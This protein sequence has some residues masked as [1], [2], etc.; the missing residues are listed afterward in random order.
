MPWTAKD[1]DRH[2]K[3]LS[4]RQKRQW[5]AVA[6]SMLAACMKKGGSQS[7]CEGRAIRGANSTVGDPELSTKQ[8]F[9][10]NTALTVP[11][12]RLTLNECEFLTAPA[13]LIVCGV[14]N[15][16]LI[17]EEALLPEEW[18][19]VPVTIG[20]PIDANG[21]PVSARSSE[22]LET[23]A[24]GHLTNARLGMGYREG[25]PVRS[26]QADIWIDTARIETLGGAAL[27][28]MQML[29]RQ[30]PLEVSTGF[31]SAGLLQNGVFLGTPYAEVHNRIDPDHLALLPNAIGACSWENGG[32][33]APRLHEHA[34]GCQGETCTC[35][36]AAVPAQ[37]EEAPSLSR[38]Q[39]LWR[40]VREVLHGESDSPP[41]ATN[42]TDLDIR[43]ALMG[44]L[45]REQ[46]MTMMPWCIEDLDVANHTF[47]YHE[48]GRLMRRGWSI[49][50][51]I[52]TLDA[53]GEDVQRDTQYR[54][55]P[56]SEVDRQGMPGP[57]TYEQQETSMPAPDVIKRRVN[58][59]IANAR[60]RW[61]EED[62]HMLESCDEA[63]LIRLEHQ[64][65]EPLPTEP[66]PAPGEPT[67]MEEALETIPAQFRETMRAAT[68]AYTKR[69]N[70]MIET[71]VANKTNP[72]SREELE[73]MHADRLEKLLTMSGEPV[74]GQ[75]PAANG[76]NY[77]GRRMPHL[78]LVP[79]E[80][81]EAPPSPPDTMGL[82][83]EEQKRLGLR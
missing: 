61:T 83:I 45:T 20:H 50:N 78:R 43:E 18:D 67:T 49:D 24:V 54:P 9:T 2:K 36:A 70:A 76:A 59:L 34:C 75:T 25:H 16:A 74:P 13:V 66:P 7:E 80:E 44:A 11:P 37:G 35:A 5:A 32:C 26:L 53:V 71:L 33:G 73:L 48:G 68:D 63:F 22:V 55:V 19:F 64:P 46:G 42:Q 3:G 28:A 58:A 47:T 4:A 29:E 41:L 65:L 6:N 77:Q 38:L 51:G 39:R 72:F 62:R 31:H 56:T 69:K 79:S 14:L 17:T 23:Y 10:I 81:D 27:Q 57:E 82:V 15:N 40:L 52:I 21:T 8:R 1:A 30:E 12:K 60:T